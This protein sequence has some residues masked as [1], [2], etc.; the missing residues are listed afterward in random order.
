MSS[1]ETVPIVSLRRTL[2]YTFSS[3]MLITRY[4]ICTWFSKFHAAFMIK[5]I[6]GKDYGTLYTYDAA[7]ITIVS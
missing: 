5:V 2:R 7:I 1:E 4:N 6:S 3:A